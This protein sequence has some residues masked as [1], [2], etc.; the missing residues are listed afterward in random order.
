MQL[1]Y[2]LVLGKENF[3]IIIA[4]MNKFQNL[5]TFFLQGI[6]ILKVQFQTFITQKLFA[7]LQ[8]WDC[9]ISL[10]WKEK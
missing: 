6:R 1:P 7:F 9:T 4:I 3:V 10:K 5:K 2:E 8:I